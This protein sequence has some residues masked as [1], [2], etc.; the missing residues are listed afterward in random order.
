[1]ANEARSGEGR[2]V[3]LLFSWSFK[4][5]KPYSEIGGH[6]KRF[7]TIHPEKGGLPKSP[8]RPLVHSTTSRTGPRLLVS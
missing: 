1:M 5:R 2:C 7:Q 6:Q 8:S 4:F 3:S